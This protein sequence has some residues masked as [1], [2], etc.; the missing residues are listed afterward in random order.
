MAGFKEQLCTRSYL[1]ILLDIEIREF[2]I[3]AEGNKIYNISSFYYT[4]KG[5]ER[6]IEPIYDGGISF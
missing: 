2:N 4:F 3:A 5:I 1:S 6:V